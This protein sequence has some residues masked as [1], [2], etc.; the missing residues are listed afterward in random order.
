[1][2]KN[3]DVKI[4]VSTETPEECMQLGNLLQNAVNAVDN[5]DL[6]KLLSKVK[7]NPKIVKT[8]LKFI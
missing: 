2:M 8:A 3:Y 6:V 5:K 4:R 1:M 7:E